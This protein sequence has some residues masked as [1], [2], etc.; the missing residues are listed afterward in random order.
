MLRPEWIAVGGD[1]WIITTLEY[2]GR[3][4]CRLSSGVSGFVRDAPYLGGPQFRQ[5]AVVCYARTNVAGGLMDVWYGSPGIDLSTLMSA[6][7]TLTLALAD[8]WYKCTWKCC[9]S[10]ANKLVQK[11]L[12]DIQQGADITKAGSFSSYNPVGLTYSGGGYGYISDAK[13][14]GGM[15]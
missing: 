12:D 15:M 7:T 13:I 2:N 5:F 8:T 10:G 6:D 4:V 11:Y 3:A 1:A 9:T 14:F